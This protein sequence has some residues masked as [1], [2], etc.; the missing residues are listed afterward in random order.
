M[1]AIL[2]DCSAYDI[3]PWVRRG[4]ADKRRETS[5]DEGDG[6]CSSGVLHSRAKNA[7][8][9]RARSFELAL[10]GRRLEHSMIC[11]MLVVAETTCIKGKALSEIEKRWGSRGTHLRHSSTIRRCVLKLM[12]RIIHRS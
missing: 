5:K 10:R 3:C 9:R 12:E 8:T 6:R 2:S 1:P 4:D 11:R 7:R